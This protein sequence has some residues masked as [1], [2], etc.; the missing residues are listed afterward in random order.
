[1]TALMKKINVLNPSFLIKL[2]N[3]NILIR[4]LRKSGEFS[5]Q[6]MDF[7]EKEPILFIKVHCDNWLFDMGVSNSILKRDIDVKIIH[8]T[9]YQGVV[10]RWHVYKRV[11]FIDITVR[12]AHKREPKPVYPRWN[13]LPPSIRCAIEHRYGKQENEVF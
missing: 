7:S 3:V 8:E 2:A 9:I 5:I 1:M 4:K 13:Y 10:L 12:T 11:P 6:Y